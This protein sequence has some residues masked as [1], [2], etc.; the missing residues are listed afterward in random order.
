MRILHCCL[1]AF[2]IDDAGYQE[3]ILPKMHKLQGHDVSIIASTETYIDNKKLGYV[4][5]R[6]YLSG[7]EI[8]VTRLGYSRW[9]PHA[10]AKK[11]RS[12]PGLTSALEQAN[13]DIIFLHNCQ[14]WDTHK[15]INFVREHPNVKVY[16]DGHSDFICLLYTSPSPRDGLL[17]RMPSS[18]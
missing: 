16:V 8:P 11:V 9:L 4:A 12:Y 2:Y 1:A 15:I 14:F 5:P 17:S 18:A 7:D 13:P 10:L 6:Q 3:N